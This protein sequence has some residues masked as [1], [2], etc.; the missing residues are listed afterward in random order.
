MAELEK[1]SRIYLEKS[2]DWLNDPEI[3]FLTN[4]PDFSRADQEKWYNDIQKK[5]NYKIWGLSD[6]GKP[7]G[8]FGIKNI[9]FDEGFGEYWGFIGEKEYWGKGIGKLI[10]KQ[11][12]EIAKTEFKLK[13]IYL[14]VLKGNLIAINLYKKFEFKE[15]GTDSKNIIMKKTINSL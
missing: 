6:E 12:I 4:T 13:E 10:L 2:W 5:E 9:D 15:I 11:I 3:K 8:I 7:I 14:K 1:Y